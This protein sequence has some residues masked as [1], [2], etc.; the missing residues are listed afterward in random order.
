[1]S[2]HDVAIVTQPA[3]GVMHDADVVIS[4]NRA[5]SERIPRDAVHVSWIQDYRL[6]DEPLYDES[7]LPRDVIYTY[8]EGWIIGVPHQHWKNYRGSLL[9]AVDAKLLAY[10]PIPQDLDLSIAGYLH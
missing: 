5:R 7:C 6:G 4:I 9:T 10:P 2:G 8:G 1:M 3:I